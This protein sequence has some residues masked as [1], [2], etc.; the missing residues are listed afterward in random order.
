MFYQTQ[1]AHRSPKGLKKSVFCPWWPWPL[2]L[3]F[4]LVWARDQTRL[5]CQFGANP[6]SD[7][8]IYFTHKQKTTDWRHKKTE[9]SAV[10]CMR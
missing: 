7:S 5:P 9:P 2:T 10:H 3:I 8:P 6:F 4:K 1:T